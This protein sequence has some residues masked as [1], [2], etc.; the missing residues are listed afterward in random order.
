MSKRIEKK[1]EEVINKTPNLMISAPPKI[2]QVC[3]TAENIFANFLT[4]NF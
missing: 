2:K 1:S 3:F 4:T